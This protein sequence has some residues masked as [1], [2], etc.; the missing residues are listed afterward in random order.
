MLVTDSLGELLAAGLRK[1]DGIHRSDWERAAGGSL[2]FDTFLKGLA[3]GGLC[4][5][6]DSFWLDET[7][8]NIADLVV[9]QLYLQMMQKFEKNRQNK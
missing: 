3:V 7:T 9:P 2:D 8:L 5:L 6:T 4:R 1:H